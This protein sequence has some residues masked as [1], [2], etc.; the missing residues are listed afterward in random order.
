MRSKPRRIS[1]YL[2][3]ARW[4][5]L[6]IRYRIEKLPDLS[7]HIKKCQSSDDRAD[8]HKSYVP[9][10]QL[11]RLLILCKTHFRK[12]KSRENGRRYYRHQ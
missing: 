9:D 3:S 10:K 4:D 11:E 6:R 1:K 12:F 8:K 7:I 5:H 2:W